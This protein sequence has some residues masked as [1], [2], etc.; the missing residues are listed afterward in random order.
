MKTNLNSACLIWDQISNMK[1]NPSYESQTFPYRNIS[2][3]VVRAHQPSPALSEAEAV[4]S[5]QAELKDQTDYMEKFVT[6]GEEKISS[7]INELLQLEVLKSY[8]ELNM[9]FFQNHSDFSLL[10]LWCAGFHLKKGWITS[11]QWLKSFLL[12]L[13]GCWKCCFIICRFIF[14]YGLKDPVS[15]VMDF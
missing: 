2:W 7:P 1:A 4:C 9:F 6:R 13:L 14:C 10:Q 5:Q 15:Y 8:F 12:L 11:P 3:T